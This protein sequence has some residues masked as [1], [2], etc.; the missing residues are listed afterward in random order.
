LPMAARTRSQIATPTTFGLRVATWLF[1][2]TRSRVRLTQLLPRLLLVQL[3]GASGTLSVY[4]HR[5]EALVHGLAE[6]L[7][8]GTAGKPWHAERDSIAEFASW[9]SLL[10]GALGKMGADLMLLGRMEI[11]E[12]KA[13]SGGGSSTMPQ[14][15][16]PVAAEAL[17]ALARFNAGQVGLVHQ[18]LI[19]AEERDATSWP[20][21]WMALPQ[22]VVATG[23]A[24][25]HAENLATTLSPDPARMRA[26]LDL[27]GGGA[28]AEA[29]TFA[30]AAHMPRPEAQA[31]LKLATREAAE[32]GVSLAETLPNLTDI[33]VDWRRVLDPAAAT[34]CA[35]VM[36]RNAAS[37]WRAGRLH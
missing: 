14:K 32:K 13:G 31:L 26:N 33:D 9:L 34:G 29:A 37:D 11:S 30:L 18:A 19:H 27:G 35:A 12:L 15:S 6:R 2:L 4:D 36:A 1:P 22:M 28:M 8:L 23:A 5:A 25:R 21:E 7:G 3:G 17:V 10:A 16:N 20:L 24:L